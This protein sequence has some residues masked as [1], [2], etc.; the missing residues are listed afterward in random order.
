M[1]LST[2]EDVLKELSKSI[3]TGELKEESLKVLSDNYEQIEKEYES[4]NDASKLRFSALQPFIAETLGLPESSN[5]NVVMKNWGRQ[6]QR[7]R[8]TEE[9]IKDGDVAVVMKNWGR[10]GKINPMLNS[11]DINNDV[12][13]V[14][15]NWGRQGS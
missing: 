13:V 14:M 1:K 7:G 10:Q 6:G 5:M 15:K 4:L 12:S 9:D 3:A 11:K 2:L 8:I